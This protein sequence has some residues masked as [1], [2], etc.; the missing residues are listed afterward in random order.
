ME[1]LG[2]SLAVESKSEVDAKALFLL[3]FA[4]ISEVSQKTKRFPDL[5]FP[6]AQV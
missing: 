6:G 2:W 4:L 3:S 5:S 1:R